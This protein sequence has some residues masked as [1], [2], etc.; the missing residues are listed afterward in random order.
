MPAAQAHRAAMV[1]RTESERCMEQSEMGPRQEIDGRLEYFGLRLMYVRLDAGVD[2][3]EM[4][5]LM[6]RA[7]CT[8]LKDDYEAIEAEACVPRVPQVFLDAVRASLCLDNAEVRRLAL[9]LGYLLIAGEYDCDFAHWVYFWG[10][11]D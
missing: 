10:A 8:M 9:Y 3:D 5:R 11:G 2:V 7:R 4:L 6:S 1:N